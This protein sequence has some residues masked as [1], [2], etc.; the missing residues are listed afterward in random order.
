MSSLEKTA[1]ALAVGLSLLLGTTA[2]RGQLAVGD[3]FPPL[4][5]AR[6]EGSLPDTAGRVTVVDFWASWC[7]PC[8]AAFPALG[9]LHAEFAPR[10]VA[11]LGISVDERAQDY[12]A[13]LKKFSPAFPTARDATQALVSAV[14]PPAMP[15]TYVLGRDGRVRAIL[16]GFRGADS[17]RALHAAVT[18]ALAR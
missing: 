15:T 8:K 16:T 1:R 5:A 4:H 13:F 10:G 2:T 11:V 7:A 14:R 17:E 9:R 6:L 12:A 18:D 3:A